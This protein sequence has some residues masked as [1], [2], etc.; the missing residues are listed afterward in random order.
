MIAFVALFDQLLRAVRFVLVVSAGVFAAFCVLDW[1]VRT[2]RVNL[3]GPLARFSRSRIDPILEPIERRVLRA[4]GNPVS[5]PLWALAA[6]VIGGILL[7]SVLDFL[8]S[9]ILGLAFALQ[10]GPGGILK[11][12]VSWTFDFL[13]IAILVRVVSS[14]LPI[15]PYSPWIRWSYAVSEPLLKPLR[16]VIPAMGPIDITPIIAYFLIGFLQDAVLRMM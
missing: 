3:F 7:I 2:R 6:V 11:L 10:T 1:L 8:R 16:Q 14:W 4:G 9:E 12:L 5:A 15:S 13:R